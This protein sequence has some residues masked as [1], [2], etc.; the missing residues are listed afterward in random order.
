MSLGLKKINLVIISPPGYIHALG[1][2]DPV[3]MFKQYFERLGI[4]VFLSKSRLRED[5]LNFCF[6]G[7][8]NPDM[9]FTPGY[10]IVVVNLEQL[11]AAKLPAKYLAALKEIPSVDYS[12]ENLFKHFGVSAVFNSGKFIPMGSESIPPLVGRNDYLADFI[13]FGSMNDHR[14]QVIKKV[15]GCGATVLLFDS[16][17]YGPERDFYI[18]KCR[19]CLQ[20]PYY[21]GR[22]FEDIRA[23]LSLSLGVPVLSIGGSGDSEIRRNACF[24]V[25]S[26][27]LDKFMEEVFRTDKFTERADSM[28]KWFRNRAPEILDFGEFVRNAEKFY[29][30]GKR[31]SKESPKKINI[32]SGNAYLWGWLNVDNDQLVVPDVNIDLSSEHLELPMQCSLVSGGGHVIIDAEN[33]TY[34]LMKNV[35][36]YVGDVSTLMTN[37][38]RLLKV[39]GHAEV[40]VPLAGTRT[41][42]DDPRIL[43]EFNE[44]SFACFTDRFWSLGWFHQRFSVVSSEYRGTDMGSIAEKSD[45][46][47]MRVVMEK[48]ET[49][50]FERN[51]ARIMSANFSANKW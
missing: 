13:F 26:D 34:V 2:L 45:A 32:G 37:V 11:A 46:A 14:S 18:R 25:N 9:L 24:S 12:N 10:E 1:F 43:R 30:I 20:I 5:C 42:R 21:D 50:P 47:F 29:S 4:E 48:I 8:L 7:H 44:G 39:G 17:L 28:I 23:S 41:A 49:S 3:F 31:Q 6:G 19:C 38:L 40:V 15:E 16:P 51:V 33:Y 36:Q 22:V 27:E 35:L